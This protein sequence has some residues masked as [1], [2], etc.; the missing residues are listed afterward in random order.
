MSRNEKIKDIMKMNISNNEK[1]KLIQQLY[2][3][4]NILEKEKK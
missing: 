1:N 2:M 3:N 4:N